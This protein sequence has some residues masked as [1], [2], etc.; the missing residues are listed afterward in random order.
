MKHHRGGPGTL[1]SGESRGVKDTR[2]RGGDVDRRGVRNRY[3]A[4]VMNRADV[5]AGAISLVE[6]KRNLADDLRWRN[7]QY[8]HG[9]AVH[10]DLHAAQTARN[11]A[12]RGGS[13]RGV[14]G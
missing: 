5:D 14:I 3:P 13:H 12:P 10:I 6:E 8:R 4:V 2:V 9:H 11:V 1:L 7:P